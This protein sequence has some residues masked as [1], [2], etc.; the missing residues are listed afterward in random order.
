[1]KI[2]V[3][4][5]ILS[6]EYF[7]IVAGALGIMLFLIMLSNLDILRIAGK[8]FNTS[9]STKEIEQSVNR[10]TDLEKIFYAYP[11]P[12]GFIIVVASSYVIFFLFVQLDIENILNMINMKTNLRPFAQAL[13]QTAHVFCMLSMIVSIIFGIIMMAC[14]ESAEKISL[15]CSQ[16][17][18]TEQ[19]QEKLDETV[20][21]DTDTIC[22]LHHK[23][24]GVL[25]LMVS[26][27]LI[28]FAVSNI[29]K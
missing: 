17:L 7:S 10:Q 12:L 8:L 4:I 15:F 1:M 3:D 22:F 11:K 23:I 20:M 28:L 29:M 19:F 2:L 27:L 18:N 25:G 9:I 26:V 14:K 16:W 6:S 21:K 13:L 24:L 5:F